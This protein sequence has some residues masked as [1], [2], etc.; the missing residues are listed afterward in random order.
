M[1]AVFVSHSSKDQ[2]VT[3]R[4]C[5]RLEAAGVAAPWADFDP[6]H[7]IP[8]GRNWERELYA[9]LRQADAVVFIASDESVLSRWCFAE[10]ALARSLRRPVFPIRVDDG[11]E[12]EI[13]KNEQWIDLDDPDM[14]GRLKAGF[15]A[16]GLDDTN[17]FTR[18]RTRS[19]TLTALGTRTRF[20]P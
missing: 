16:A 9:Q 1:P 18:D 5:R 3:E 17:S 19:P 12:L 15:A 13:L 4:V 6:E 7:G 20:M 11:A 14:V 10:L 8:A 2:S